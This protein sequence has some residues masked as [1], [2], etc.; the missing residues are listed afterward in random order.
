MDRLDPSH[1]TAD[2]EDQLR[3]FHQYSDLISSNSDWP[4]TKDVVIINKVSVDGISA[5]YHVT[6]QEHDTTALFDTSANILAILE[7]MFDSLPQQPKLLISNTCTVM[8][9]NGTDLG[10]IGHCSLTFK[11]GKKHF[12]DKFIVLWGW[13]RDF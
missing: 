2:E 10:L 12:R 7:N 13:L 4:A 5:M 8:P 11:L 1:K 6:V 3:L 9:A